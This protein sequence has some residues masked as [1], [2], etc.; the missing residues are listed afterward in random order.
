MKDVKAQLFLEP[1]GRNTAPALTLAA[2]QAI[3]KGEDPILVVT[4]ADQ[5][6]QDQTLFTKSLHDAIEELRIRVQS[7]C[8]ALN[9]PSL[10]QGLVISK[11]IRQK[12]RHQAFKVSKFYGET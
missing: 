12:M 4:P 8:W 10:I 3:D 1:I 6:V 11:K 9:L 7:W 5:T 2:L